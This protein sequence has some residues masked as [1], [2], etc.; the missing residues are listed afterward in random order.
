[1]SSLEAVF[2]ESAAGTLAYAMAL[3]L[4][5]IYFTG[6]SSV[7][8]GM[9]QSYPIAAVSAM[10]SPWKGPLCCP[11]SPEEGGAQR[12]KIIPGGEGNGALAQSIAAAAF[13]LM[14]RE[15]FLQGPAQRHHLFALFLGG[16][17]PQA[18]LLYTSRCV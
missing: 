12:G 3:S 5:H 16:D 1:M 11:F 13:S 14:G 6:F 8:M 7:P 17:N 9:K 2:S 18:C 10:L 4:I 15:K